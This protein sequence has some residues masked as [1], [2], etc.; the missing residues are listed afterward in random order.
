MAKLF[1][2]VILAVRDQPGAVIEQGKKERVHDS[3]P[4]TQ[5]GTVHDIGHPQCVVQLGLEGLGRA[6]A[7][8]DKPGPI[9]PFAHQ[10]PVDA[11]ETI[12]CRAAKLH[13]PSLSNW[14]PNSNGTKSCAREYSIRGT[15]SRWTKTNVKPMPHRTFSADLLRIACCLA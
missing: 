11:G 4:D 8:S 1:V 5:G 2:V 7:L 3:I 15:D 14:T 6:A 10:Q 12:K 13:F 9:Q